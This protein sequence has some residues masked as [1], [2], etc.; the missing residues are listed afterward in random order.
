LKK[1][2]SGCTKSIFN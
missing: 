2:N 1:D